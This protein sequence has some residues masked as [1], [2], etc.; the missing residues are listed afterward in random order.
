MGF[1]SVTMPEKLKKSGKVLYVVV[2]NR[3]KLAE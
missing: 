2:V 3:V 1:W